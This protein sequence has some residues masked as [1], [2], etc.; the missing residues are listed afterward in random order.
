MAP[1]N[2]KVLW[3]VTRRH[4]G[5]CRS[6]VFLV[7]LD[8]D[9]M[10]T[11]RIKK[12][13]LWPQRDLTSTML[14]WL[15]Y[16]MFLAGSRS[17]VGSIYTHYMKRMKD[18]MSALKVKNASEWSSQLWSNL[19]SYKKGWYGYAECRNECVTCSWCFKLQPFIR[20]TPWHSA[21]Q[22]QPCVDTVYVKL[23]P[24]N[25]LPASLSCYSSAQAKFCT[26]VGPERHSV[27]GVLHPLR[28]LQQQK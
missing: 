2:W 18:H 19:S 1:L 8:K 20:T 10:S 11:L 28:D 21:Y 16:I 4:S 24:A 17:G 7:A 12:Q 26:V 15:S 27:S 13:I 3:P 9:H 5:K 23:K 14:Y 22:H 6:L 25:L